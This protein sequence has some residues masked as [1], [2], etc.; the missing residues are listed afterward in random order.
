MTEQRLGGAGP[1]PRAR[2]EICDAEILLHLGRLTRCQAA[3][4]PPWQQRDDALQALVGAISRLQ[5]LRR[6]PVHLTLSGRSFCLD[7]RQ[8]RVAPSA[9][10]AIQWLA[11]FWTRLGVGR[12]VF[13]C[14]ITPWQLDALADQLR[15]GLRDPE[16]RRG[17]FDETSPVQLH[18]LARGPVAGEPAGGRLDPALLL[19]ALLQQARR[20]W[21]RVMARQ[22]VDLRIMRRLLICA[23]QQLQGGDEAL[24]DL[25]TAPPALVM[26]EAHLVQT[27]LLSMRTGMELSLPPARLLELGVAATLH[28]LVKVRTGGADGEAE[29]VLLTTGDDRAAAARFT[30]GLLRNLV[31]TN[32]L[33]ART[34]PCL[35]VLHEAQAEF[36]RDDLYPSLGQRGR[37][38]SLY[39]QIIALS[40]MS[41]LSDRL[42]AAGD[43]ALAGKALASYLESLKHIN[44][45]LVDTFYRSASSLSPEPEPG[46]LQPLRP[47][48]E[49]ESPPPPALPT[50]GA[51][52][53]AGQ[54]PKLSPT[55]DAPRILLVDDEPDIRMSLRHLLESFGFRVEEAEDGMW[56]AQKIRREQYD[57]V[58]LDMMMPHMDGF[59]LLRSLP[60]DRLET[61]PIVIL[62]ARGHDEEI[63]QGYKLGA[64]HYLVKPFDNRTILSAVSQLI[65]DLAPE[66]VHVIEQFLRGT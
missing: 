46:G 48:E 32:G 29:P 45:A 15:R 54:M 23:I 41:S 8:V 9:M 33:T 53:A 51:P 7:W 31:Q 44:P 42:D 59:D 65:R 22:R 52:L 61:L 12:M 58:I 66:Q 14:P 28:G 62:S 57:L 63:L 43:R 49:F 24:L 16:A 25:V 38:H 19:D 2:L 17:L 27:A 30:R 36:A 21:S 18:P 34:L 47:R 3:D 64:T 4:D 56:G 39:G 37:Q 50:D 6:G 35:L 40:A 26:P 1:S 60:A 55:A 20:S 11:R 13:P 10:E 5:Q